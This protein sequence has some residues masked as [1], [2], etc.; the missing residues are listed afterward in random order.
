MKKWK[1]FV[2]FF[3]KLYDD[4]YTIDKSLDLKNFTFVKVN[5]EYEMEIDGKLDYDIFIEHDFRIY[6]P[7]LQK[8]GYARSLAVNCIPSANRTVR[9]LKCAVRE[10]N[11]AHIVGNDIFYQ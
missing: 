3:K 7:E 11:P 1:I 4:H 9:F 6:N 10:S 5:D 2:T 8:R